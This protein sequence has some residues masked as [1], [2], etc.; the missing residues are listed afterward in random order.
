MNS[1]VFN[2]IYYCMAIIV[3]GIL[4][5]SF[6][7]CHDDNDDLGDNTFSVKC[8]VDSTEQK[9][10]ENIVRKSEIGDAQ[11]QVEDDSI[12]N[13]VR[14]SDGLHYIVPRQVGKTKI[15]V[16]AKGREYSISIR[17]L[18]EGCAFWKFT[19]IITY[20]SCNTEIKDS[21]QKD[22][23]E[24]NIFS[25]V[26]DGNKLLFEYDPRRV[27]WYQNEEN[28]SERLDLS[29]HYDKSSSGY[30]FIKRLLPKRDSPIQEQKLSFIL[31]E[32]RYVESHKD[33]D[34]KGIFR[35][36]QTHYYQDLY[37]KDKV[38]RVAID[39]VMESI[40]LTI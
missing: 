9:A 25:E 7:S 4:S 30:I 1:K 15:S 2:L 18:C 29:F 22:L 20:L 38:Q 32:K 6:I 12:L 13:V 11:I 35:Y 33:Y 34:K 37:G 23:R 17:V 39:Y 14:N 5:L 19:K 21:I 26:K 3:M 27:T 36:D 16:K 31:T 8:Y 28:P 24:R 10:I 40:N